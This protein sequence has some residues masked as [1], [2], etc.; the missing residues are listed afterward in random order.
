MEEIK[1]TVENLEQNSSNV[2][3]KR[4]APYKR[5]YNKKVVRMEKKQKKKK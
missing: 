5:N 1:N 3:P 4:K 2:K